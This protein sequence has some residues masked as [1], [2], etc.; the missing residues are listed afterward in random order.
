MVHCVAVSW[1][2]AV[3]R[4][5]RSLPAVSSETS[6]SY[7]FSY[8]LPATRLTSRTGSSEAGSEPWI[9]VTGVRFWPVGVVV[10]DV[11][12]AH[13]ARTMTIAR[14]VAPTEGLERIFH[15]N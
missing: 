13:A 1:V 4:R 12:G 10:V 8:T 15:L 7:T 2:H 5:G 11:P 14:R 3:A 6:V 9:T